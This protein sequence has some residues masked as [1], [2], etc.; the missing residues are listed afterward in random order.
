VRVRAGA[1][2]CAVKRTVKSWLKGILREA[3][4]AQENYT[5]EFIG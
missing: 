5:R 1:I 4:R 3:K 2:V